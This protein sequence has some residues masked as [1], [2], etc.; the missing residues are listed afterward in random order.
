MSELSELSELS[1]WSELSELTEW[2]E[3]SELTELTEWSEWSYLS[4]MSVLSDLTILSDLTYKNRC[5]AKKQFFSDII[6]E[7]GFLGNYPRLKGEKEGER[8]IKTSGDDVRQDDKQPVDSEASQPLSTRRGRPKGSGSSK[9][10]TVK[11]G[12]ANIHISVSPSTRAKMRLY[13]S[14]A[15]YSKGRSVSNDQIISLAMDLLLEKEC[16]ELL[17]NFNKI[18]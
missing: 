3:W 6:P 17:K 11:E 5:M 13:A 12:V 9:V 18:D 14:F 7:D 10:K 8:K 1:E 2:S 15:G 4:D 16:P